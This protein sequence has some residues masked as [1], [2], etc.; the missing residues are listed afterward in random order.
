MGRLV[1]V[2][3][4]DDR[5]Y[6]VGGVEVKEYGGEVFKTNSNGVAKLLIDGSYVTIFVNG[7]RAYRGSVSSIDGPITVDTCG[8]DV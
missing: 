7:F 3:V 8:R 5:G 2:V 1:T 4:V 6:G